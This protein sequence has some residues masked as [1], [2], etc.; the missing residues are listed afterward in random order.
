M[1]VLEPMALGRPVIA[2]R[3]GG[4]PEQVRDGVDGLLV[5]SG[6]VLQLAAA[7]RV[8]ADDA[9]L[10]ERLGRSAR[11]RA[12]GEFSPRAH[13]N[14]LLDVYSAALASAREEGGR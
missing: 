7:L 4:I 6:D 12:G 9:P 8:L 14:G 5:D 2:T 13:L 1:S 3:M 10:A 11:Q